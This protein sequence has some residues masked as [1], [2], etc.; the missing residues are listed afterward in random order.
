LPLSSTEVPEKLVPSN[1]AARIYDLISEALVTLNEK[2]HQVDKGL[3]TDDIK[4][5]QADERIRFL[6][7]EAEYLSGHTS[8][9]ERDVRALEKLINNLLQKIPF[10][11]YSKLKHL[12]QSRGD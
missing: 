10:R 12:F 1:E 6:L 4:I 11:V 5:S 2:L 9:I 8:N 7:R 3:H